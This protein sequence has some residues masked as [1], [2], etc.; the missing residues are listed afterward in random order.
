MNFNM[1]PSEGYKGFEIRRLG[2]KFDWLV[3]A[4]SFFIQLSSYLIERN[5]SLTSI[6]S[7]HLIWTITVE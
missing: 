6:N 2:T 3:G 4:S 7:Q 5:I 1:Q